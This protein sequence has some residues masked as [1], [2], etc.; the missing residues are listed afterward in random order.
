M[1]N[2][3][4]KPMERYNHPQEPKKILF[5]FCIDEFKKVS[6][7]KQL[8]ESPIPNEE[9]RKFHIKC[10][11]NISVGYN[12]LRMFYLLAMFWLNQELSEVLWTVQS[13]PWRWIAFTY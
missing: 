3:A 8:L 6:L 5:I 12:E 9:K 4:T 13:V 10:K 11:Q 7:V 2:K 1:H